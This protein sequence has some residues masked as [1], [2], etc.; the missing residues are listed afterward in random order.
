MGELLLP[1]T[2]LPE[3]NLASR[4]TLRFPIPDIFAASNIKR[5]PNERP[6]ISN[7]KLKRT[8]DRTLTGCLTRSIP[9]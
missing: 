5:N 2:A 3:R 6:N 7:R 4:A 1:G 9:F 8:I